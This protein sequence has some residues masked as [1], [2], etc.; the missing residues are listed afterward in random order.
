MDKLH[1]MQV[2]VRVVEQGAFTRAA[3]D[4]GI[5]RASITHAIGELEKRLGVR[6]LNRTTRRL[7]LTDE[8][9]A[10]YDDCVRLLDQLAETEDRLSGTR[11]V[12]RGHLR[13]SVPQS[14]S[15]KI[16][17]PALMTFMQRYPDLSVELIITDRAVNLI[18]E[19]VDCAMRG[20]EVPPDSGLV[21]R[22]LAKAYWLTCATPAYFEAH[23]APA[24]IADLAHHECVRFISPSTGRG[25]DWMFLKDGKTETFVPHGRLRLTSLDGALDAALAGLGIAQVPDAVA[26]QSI[27][28]G[29]LQP[30]LTEFLS[31]APAL[32]LVYPGNRYL[33]AKVRAFGEYF[34]EVLPR[35]GWWSLLKGNVTAGK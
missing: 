5:S 13:V 6:L 10:Y 19:G 29:H 21:A 27:A 23:G 8:G 17:L 1:C 4:M 24:S 12:P 32:L 30:V 34:M 3:D 20:V 33:T 7:S 18:E 35:E 15:E 31:P 25:R 14:F 26:Y 22:T 9:R 11:V 2:F 28:D 16:L